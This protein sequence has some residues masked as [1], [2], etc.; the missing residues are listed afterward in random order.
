MLHT[1]ETICQGSKNTMEMNIQSRYVD[2]KDTINV[3]NSVLVKMSESVNFLSPWLSS[4]WTDFT[5]I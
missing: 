3:K 4:D 5:V 1:D 2:N